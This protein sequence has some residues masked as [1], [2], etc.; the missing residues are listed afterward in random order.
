MGVHDIRSM[1]LHVRLAQNTRKYFG[2]KL[3]M[4]DGKVQ[5]F[6]FNVVVFGYTNARAIMNA[7]LRPLKI[8]LHSHGIDVSWFVDDGINAAR[9]HKLCHLFQSY[10][11]FILKLTGWQVATE[12]TVKPSCI[13]TYLG[14]ELNTLNMT[15]TAPINKV[16]RI[17]K[18]IDTMISDFNS[19]GQVPNRQCA[20]ILG[21]AA[22]LLTSHG[23]VLQITTRYSQHF[24]AKSVIVKGWHGKFVLDHR[25]I[26]ELGLAKYFLNHANGMMMRYSEKE[27]EVIRPVHKKYLMS[28]YSPSL[29]DRKLLTMVSDAS[30]DT[31]YVY[32]A[33]DFKVVKEFPFSNSEKEA[34]STFRELASIF[35]LFTQ[36]VEFMKLAQHKLI[37]WLTDS[38]SLC[39]IIKK[40]SRVLELQEQVLAL[41]E[42]ML[43]WGIYF[44]LFDTVRGGISR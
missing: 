33:N 28:D 35:K 2:F 1:Y 34:S 15:V 26:H 13:V 39:A 8:H 44:M 14:F 3:L 19:V 41:T 24:L 40:G 21:M 7:L 31:S 16:L 36:D 29:K 17:Q 38:T 22:H 9:T 37:V 5:H 25:M 27:I 42:L 43:K 4:P 30:A 11:F 12:K 10:T 6:V 32:M 23:P 18:D 20:A